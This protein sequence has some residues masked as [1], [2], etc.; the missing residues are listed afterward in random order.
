MC[1]TALS[2]NPLHDGS[3]CT[4]SAGHGTGRADR[5]SHRRPSKYAH[6]A[7]RLFGSIKKS[8]LPR[9]LGIRDGSANTHIFFVVV[10]DLDQYRVAL[11]LDFEPQ[12]KPDPTR[13]DQALY[14]ARDGQEPHAGDDLVA[15]EFESQGAVEIDPQTWRL[16]RSASSVINFRV[17]SRTVLRRHHQEGL[18]LGVEPTKSGRKRKSPLECLLSRV[19]GWWRGGGRNF[20]S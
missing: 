8:S 14:P 20:A 13:S 3:A 11:A 7:R 19:V 1:H 2:A 15:G 6:V 16:F 18:F 4:R 5:G 9:M 10:D 12:E 17:G